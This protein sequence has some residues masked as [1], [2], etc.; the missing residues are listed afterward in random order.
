MRHWL[1][2]ACALFFVV[3]CRNETTTETRNSETAH[4]AADNTGKNARDR[5]STAVTPMDQGGNEA[6]RS[7]TQTIRKTVVGD[8]TL[9][10]SGKNVKIITESGVVTLRGPVET[11]Q[12][13]ADIVRIAQ[14]VDGV[15][16]VENQLEIAAK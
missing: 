1:T 10:T 15:K 13:K 11:A 14:H 16:R 8:D 3:G 12:E 2:A 4:V 7:I 9:S 6:D 5:D